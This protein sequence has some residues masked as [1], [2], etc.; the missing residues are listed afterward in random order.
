MAPHNVRAHLP[1]RFALFV[2]ITLSALAMGSP[3][4]SGARSASAA[5]ARFVLVGAVLAVS[6]TNLANCGQCMVTVINESPTRSLTW[7]A[8]SHGISGVT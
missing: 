1:I 2:L 5:P 6:P 3:L 4:V 7:S 8:I